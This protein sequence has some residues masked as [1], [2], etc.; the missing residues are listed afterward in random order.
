MSHC[1]GLSGCL[2]V[3]AQNRIADPPWK[4]FSRMVCFKAA[5]ASAFSS[6]RRGSTGEAI[7]TQM[8]AAPFSAAQDV[9]RSQM[10]SSVSHFL[11][12]AYCLLVHTETRPCPRPPADCLIDVLVELQQLNIETHLIGSK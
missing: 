10:R 2:R 5:L 11:L 9:R 7:L 3:G 4:L 1:E 6:T 12:T 8:L